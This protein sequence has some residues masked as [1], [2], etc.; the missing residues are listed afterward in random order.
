MLF[1][2]LPLRFQ[3]FVELAPQAA[4][5]VRQGRGR[6]EIRPQLEKA[7]SPQVR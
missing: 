7:L 2:R 6:E 1:F 4:L 5:E 3:L